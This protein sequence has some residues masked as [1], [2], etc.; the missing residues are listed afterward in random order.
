MFQPRLI[1]QIPFL[2]ESGF[3][4]QAGSSALSSA[5]ACL[6]G[7][8]AAGILD[9]PLVIAY[10]LVHTPGLLMEQREYS[11]AFPPAGTIESYGLQ[12]AHDRLIDF[13][14]FMLS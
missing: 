3:L 7:R 1:T 9:G 6:P 14:E 5:S 12:V 13:A 11:V 8:P 10:R 4:S 2:V